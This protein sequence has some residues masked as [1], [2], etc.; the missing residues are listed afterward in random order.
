MHHLSK[1]TLSYSCDHDN[2]SAITLKCVANEICECLTLIINQSITTGIFPDQL[3]VAEV[4][5]IFMKNDLS[6]IKNYRPNSV[7]PTVVLDETEHGFVVNVL[8][9]TQI[10]W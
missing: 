2:L 8:L 5:P 3:K 9:F 10:L 4:V 7:L 1:L 6:D